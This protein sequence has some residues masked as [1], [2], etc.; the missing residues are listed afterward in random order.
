[1]TDTR[2]D[3]LVAAAIALA[4]QFK[5]AKDEIQFQCRLPDSLTDAMAQAGLFQLL[6][7]KDHRR[8]RDRPRHRLPRG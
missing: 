5:A 6:R 1:M 8:P 4:P 7:A 3:D 2:T